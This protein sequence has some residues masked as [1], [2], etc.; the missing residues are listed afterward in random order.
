MKVDLFCVTFVWFLSVA[1][2]LASHIFFQKKLGFF[3]L[4]VTK[5]PS[6]VLHICIKGVIPLF[7][8]CLRLN[9]TTDL[10]WNLVSPWKNTSN[11]GPAWNSTVK[12]SCAISSFH[13]NIL[14]SWISADI[15]AN[16]FII[17][18]LKNRILMHEMILYMNTSNVLN[19]SNWTFRQ[20]SFYVSWTQLRGVGFPSFSGK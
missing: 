18:H 16:M 1:V 3:H 19:N 5:P 17:L 13:S 10:P 7:F 20:L 6:L 11:Q 2:G 9:N 15:W 14:Q 4:L 12:I 8:E